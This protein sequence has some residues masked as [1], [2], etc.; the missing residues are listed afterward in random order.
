MD[1]KHVVRFF[2]GGRRILT[3]AAVRCHSAERCHA[4]TTGRDTLRS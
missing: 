3:P 2:E 4:G 1:V